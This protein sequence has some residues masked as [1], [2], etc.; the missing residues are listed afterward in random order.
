MK[1]KFIKATQVDTAVRLDF[2]HSTTQLFGAEQV[3]I[4]SIW[5]RDKQIADLTLPQPGE[6]VDLSAYEVI[7]NSSNYLQYV[8]KA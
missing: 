4:A 8:L 7:R 5:V 3:A 2:A 6:E 1:K